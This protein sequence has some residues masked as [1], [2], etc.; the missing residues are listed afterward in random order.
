M[1]ADTTHREQT[2]RIFVELFNR[3]HP[4]WEVNGDTTTDL[5]PEDVHFLFS[6]HS[7]GFVG[8]D[9]DD[10]IQMFLDQEIW[11]DRDTEENVG[12]L[13][14]LLGYFA[15]APSHTSE[16]WSSIIQIFE[17]LQSEADMTCELFDVEQVD[18]HEVRAMLIDLVEERRRNEKPP[19][20]WETNGFERRLDL[21][22]KLD[23]PVE[24]IDRF[25]GMGARMRANDDMSIV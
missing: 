9:G 1:V 24:Q 12:F 16:N 19:G 17:T 10:N 21:A 22:K 8:T 3:A 14:W 23:Y 15:D 7:I 6:A 20:H 25:S 18:W 2:T 11:N 4:D 5:A 13:T